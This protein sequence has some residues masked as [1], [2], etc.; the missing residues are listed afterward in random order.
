[1]KLYNLAAGGDLP[2]GLQMLGFARRDKTDES[3]REELEE[4]N[5]KNSRGG[6]DDELWQNFAEN[7]GYHRGNFNEPEAYQSLAR[8]LDERTPCRRGGDARYGVAAASA[9]ATAATLRGWG[10]PVTT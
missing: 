3:W 9:A 6:H 8:R 2:P 5:R 1:M 10:R 7:I 4:S